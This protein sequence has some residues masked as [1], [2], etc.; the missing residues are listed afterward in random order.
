MWGGVEDKAAERAIHC[1]IDQGITLI[2]TAP[3]YGF[4]RSE[5][6]VGRAL[7]GHRDEV[8]LA[9]K[10]GLIWNRAE[11]EFFFASDD[12]GRNAD[13]EHRIHRFLGPASIR[14]EL[15]GSLRRLRT[16]HVDLY[17]THWQDPT[18]PIAESMDAL[19]RLK[20][21]GKILAIG[22]CNATVDQMAAYRSVG[23]LDSDQEKFS[24]MDRAIEAGQLAYCRE[25]G[26]AM[27]AYSPLA[28]GL[29][30]GRIRADRQYGPGDLRAGSRRFEP[31]SLRKVNAMLDEL[32]PVAAERG[33]SLAQLVIAWTLAQPGL[34]HALVGARNE[35]QAR[36]NA[37]AAVDLG[38]EELAAIDAVLGRHAALAEADGG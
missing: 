33:L 7:G 36:E 10:C 24:M 32:R 4:G 9:T 8:V 38:R 31:D 34:T 17:Q 15:E 2:D 20:R 25:H 1:A 30:T 28:L 12:Y 14:R 16:D 6:T 19:L 22:V 23:Q 27:L 29:L 18:T 26:L 13:G 5:E 11:G 35:E 3:V 37:G 21:E